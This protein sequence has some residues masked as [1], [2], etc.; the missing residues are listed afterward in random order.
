MSPLRQKECDLIVVSTFTRWP[1]ISA[2]PIMLGLDRLKYSNYK[3]TLVL[4]LLSCIS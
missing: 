2:Y 4:V 3:L 1:S